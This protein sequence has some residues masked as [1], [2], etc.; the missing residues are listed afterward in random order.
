MLVAEGMG[1]AKVEGSTCH[2]GGTSDAG[3]KLHEGSPRGWARVVEGGRKAADDSWRREVGMLLG[4]AVS[5]GS[6]GGDGYPKGDGD[7][8]PGGTCWRQRSRRR[9][10][11]AEP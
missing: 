8:R 10:R 2:S 7:S 3:E 6:S 1:G 9:G 5:Y 11:E 4:H